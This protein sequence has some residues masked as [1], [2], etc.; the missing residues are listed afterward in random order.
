MLCPFK[1]NFPIL[2]FKVLNSQQAPLFLTEVVLDIAE[3]RIDPTPLLAI[4]KDTQQRNAGD[5]LLINEGGC[6]I[7]DLTISFHLLPGQVE[8]PTNFEP[9]FRHSLSVPFFEGQIEIDVTSAFQE[10]GVDINALVLL[11]NGRWDKDGCVVPK[12]DGSEERLTKAEV[13]ERWEKSLGQFRNEV[14]TLVGEICFATADGGSLNITSSFTRTSTLRI[15]TAWASRG[16][17]HSCT[18]PLST[19]RTPVI[20]DGCRFPMSYSQAKRTGSLSK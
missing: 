1:W 5:L 7:S 3:S 14:G 2:D 11:G 12:A 19:H 8:A 17:P 10:E 4:K 15:A 9:P 20:R 18:I 13:R 16:L 6:N